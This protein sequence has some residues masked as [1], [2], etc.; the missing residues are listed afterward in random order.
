[1]TAPFVTCTNDTPGACADCVT[2][3]GPNGNS[4]CGGVWQE[5]QPLILRRGKLDERDRAILRDVWNA[6]QDYKTVS[7][8][9]LVR[10][11]GISSGSISYRLMEPGRLIPAGWLAQERGLI[12]TLRPG[13]RFAGMDAGWP[14]ELVT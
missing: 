13:P 14:L 2:A 12:R 1:M 3:E 6:W 11:T 8:R 10:R 4:Q 9:Q 7:R 5:Q